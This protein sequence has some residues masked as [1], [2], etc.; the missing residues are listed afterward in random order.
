MIIEWV[1]CIHGAGDDVGVINEY[2][3]S[4]INVHIKLSAFSLD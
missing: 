3:D 1:F 4:F 2:L